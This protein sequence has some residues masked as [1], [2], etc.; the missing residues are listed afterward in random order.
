MKT[1]TVWDLPTRIFHWSLVFFFSFSYL[2]G[3]ELEDFHAYSG[4]VIIG[5]L[6]FRV[7]WGFIGSPYA[8]FSRFI[9]PPSTTLNLY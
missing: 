7:V 4:Y 8:R 2:S 5:L 1:V 3:D 6:I 9:Y